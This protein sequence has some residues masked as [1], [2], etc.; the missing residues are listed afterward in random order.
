MDLRIA[1]AGD[2]E[3]IA[4][5]HAAS[6]RATYRGMYSDAYLDGDLVADR[7]AVWSRRFAERTDDQH[8]LVA[9]DAGAL[10]GF[11]YACGEADDRWGTLVDNLHVRLDDHRRGLGRTLL[12]ACAAWSAGRY[13]GRPLHLWVLDGNTNARAFYEHVGGRQEDSDTHEAPGG[14]M[15]TALR[16]VWPT[17][18]ALLAPTAK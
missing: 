17:V 5:L 12:A 4:L 6:W 3:P 8:L 13:P 1:A 16:I 18:D 15:I 7:L 14:G 9:V 10:L 11:A 2:V